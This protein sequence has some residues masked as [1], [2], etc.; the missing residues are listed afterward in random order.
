MNNKQLAERIV[1]TVFDKLGVEEIAI[2]NKERIVKEVEKALEPTQPDPPKSAVEE[3]KPEMDAFG[4]ELRDL[5]N[6]NSK[7]NGS[8]TPD[9]ILAE[10]LYGC[11]ILFDR[12][13]KER[14]RWYGNKD[15]IPTID[16]KPTP[17]LGV[18]AELIEAWGKWNQN[19]DM[20][21]DNIKN[22]ESLE[23]AMARFIALAPAIKELVEVFDNVMDSAM[24]SRYT[25]HGKGVEISHYKISTEDFDRLLAARKKVG[26]V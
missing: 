24:P 14:S 17:S 13:T 21:S 9:F 16:I 25:N 5:I 1:E 7:E 15:T 6:R 26:G 8:D 10:F 23:I 12:T 20:P 18:L 4:K 11:L 3:S 2:I 19:V 22:W